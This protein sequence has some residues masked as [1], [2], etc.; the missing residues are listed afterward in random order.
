[1]DNSSSI[2]KIIDKKRCEVTGVRK[3]EAFDEKQFYFEAG[4]ATQY[5]IEDVDR[6]D[7]I[8]GSNA[9]IGGLIEFENFIKLNDKEN[10]S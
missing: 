9:A 3:L 7:N 10:E 1:M 2:V 8:D 6:N 4:R 5:M